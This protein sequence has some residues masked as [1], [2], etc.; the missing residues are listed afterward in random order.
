MSNNNVPSDVKRGSAL[1]SRDGVCCVLEQNHLLHAASVHSA[2]E[3]CCNVTC[4][5]LYNLDFL[6][7]R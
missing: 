3:M 6:S 2:V 4:A 5:S 7:C 1:D